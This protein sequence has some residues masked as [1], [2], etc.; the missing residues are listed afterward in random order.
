MNLRTKLEPILPFTVGHSHRQTTYTRT[1]WKPNKF[2]V[3]AVN[4]VNLI[5]GVS[6]SS[7][8]PLL[9]CACRYALPPVARSSHSWTARLPPSRPRGSQTAK[10]SKASRFLC[11]RSC[12]RPQPRPPEHR[13]R[14][15]DNS[16]RSSRARQTRAVAI[17]DALRDWLVAQRRRLLSKN[18]LARAI[19]YALTA[20]MRWRRYASDGRLAIDNNVA[21]RALRGVAITRK[22]F[23]S[24]GS[25]LRWPARPSW[26]RPS[27]TVLIQRLISELLPS[28]WHASSKSAPLLQSDP[29]SAGLRREAPPL[30]TG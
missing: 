24:L 6:V 23:L 18:A 11:P 17:V 29:T 21:E 16:A 12:Y 26:R 2:V 5:A 4:H 13:A 15:S 19:Q 30:I 27:S 20:R 3:N 25:E 9:L 8:I 7:R 14:Q 28:N 1:A 22:N 10:S